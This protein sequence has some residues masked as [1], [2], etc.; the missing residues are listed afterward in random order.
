MRFNIDIPANKLQD[1]IDCYGRGWEAT[2][3]DGTANP[4]TKGEHA[5]RELLAH[6]K[7][8]VINFIKENNAPVEPDT[9]ITILQEVIK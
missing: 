3:P 4:I 2:L 6:I 7:N 1:M 8:P 9:G 5:K